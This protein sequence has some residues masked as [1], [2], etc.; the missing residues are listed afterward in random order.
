MPWE[1]AKSS[2]ESIARL[3]EVN[4]AEWQRTQEFLA[5]GNN[6]PKPDRDLEAFDHETWKSIHAK[7][8]END[9][10]GVSDFIMGRRGATLTVCDAQTS[11]GWSALH[12]ASIAGANRA[13]ATCIEGKADVFLKVLIRCAVSL[14]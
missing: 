13:A 6:P 2:E 7:A 8:L 4:N 3:S 1:R 9:A 14:K 10:E 12:V 5:Q 11:N